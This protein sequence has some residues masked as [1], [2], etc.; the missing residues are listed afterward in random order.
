MVFGPSPSTPHC[1]FVMQP[2]SRR[3]GLCVGGV[4]YKG[5]RAA[6]PGPHIPIESNKPPAQLPHDRFA[7]SQY[8]ADQFPTFTF[9]VI[10][11]KTKKSFILR[12]NPVL[13]CL[14]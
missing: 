10:G 5:D 3:N 1:T 8:V 12:C 2:A 4:M 13:F 9:N 7:S 11:G 6:G 14:L